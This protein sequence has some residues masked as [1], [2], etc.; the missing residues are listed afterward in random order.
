MRII[1]NGKQTQTRCKRL[2]D[3]RVQYPRADITIY[4]GFQTEQDYPLCENDSIVLI[5]KGALP[6]YDTLESML[7][8]RHSPG[9]YAKLKKGCVAVVGL[10]GLGS[11]I[12]V[13]LARSGVGHLLLIDYDTVE[14]SNLNRQHYLISH[15]GMYKTDAI[16]QQIEQINPYITVTVKNIRVNAHNLCGLLDGFPIIC[17]ALDDPQMKAALIN[18]VLENFPHSTVIAASGMAGYESANTIQTHKKFKNLYLCGDETTEAALYH[19]LMA[20]RVQICAG[21]QANMALRL[22]LGIEEI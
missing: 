8:A 21:H 11:N 20:P 19:G 13:A 10:G 1:V 7:S 22:L 3:L 2:R 4:N 15:L 12:A 14:P 5:E 16:R 18:T 17:E 9:V 6:D